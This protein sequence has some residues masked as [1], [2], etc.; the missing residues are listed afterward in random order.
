MLAHVHVAVTSVRGRVQ[1]LAP[2]G[3]FPR[4]KKKKKDCQDCD[5]IK[6]Q[7]AIVKKAPRHTC[8]TKVLRRFCSITHQSFSICLQQSKRLTR[9]L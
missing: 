7:H 9:W 5:D 8:D 3:V 4:K 2:S 6:E 1:R